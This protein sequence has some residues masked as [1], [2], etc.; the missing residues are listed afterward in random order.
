M[1]RYLIKNNFK[2][3][4]RNKLAMAVLLLFPIITT[5]LVSSAFK[6]LLSSYDAP[7]EFTVGYRDADN[8][9]SENLDAVKE[10]GADAGLILSEFPDGEPEDIIRNNDLSA[11]VMISGGEYTVYKSRDHKTEGTITEYFFEKVMNKGVDAALDMMSR[12]AEMSSV[13]PETKID[14]MP[15]VDSINYYGIVYIVLYSGLGM[16]AATGVL[17]SEKK[18]GIEKKYHVSGLSSAQT[19]LS[20]ILPTVGLV[21]VI[22]FIETIIFR[23]MFGVQWG[24][25][26]L[27][28]LIVFLIL[29]AFSAFGIML[30]GIFNNLGLT[31]TG[32]FAAGWVLGFIGGSFETYMY[33]SISDSIK[34]LSPIYHANRALVELY[35]MGHSDYAES[36]III[37][38][39]LIVVCSA[40]AI[41]ADMIRK[42]GKA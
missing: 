22:M 24:E 38:S 6:S 31:V 36:S 23:F 11:F 37:S 30:Y 2:L 19:Y 26:L 3:M 20:H 39:V 8:F 12:D 1:I 34:Q 13:L 32:L 5:A 4:L 9:F 17:S 18:N 7:D 14:F 15:S 21:T 28:A 41:A 27:S 25:P 42:R 29:T 10:A 16:I 35:A 33:S 40:A